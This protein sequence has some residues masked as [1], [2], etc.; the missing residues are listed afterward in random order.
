MMLT[1][2]SGPVELCFDVNPFIIQQ[3]FPDFVSVGGCGSL[4]RC[5]ISRESS[6]LSIS[7]FKFPAASDVTLER[8]HM[9]DCR[10]RCCHGRER[11]AIAL[12]CKKKP[13]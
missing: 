4:Y 3:V 2:E 6:E 7:S 10:R 5:S 11:S 12:D 9:P 8:A 13:Y 1:C